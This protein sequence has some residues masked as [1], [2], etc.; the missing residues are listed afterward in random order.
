LGFEIN[1]VGDIVSPTLAKE[2]VKYLHLSL[3]F[4]WV[5]YVVYQLVRQALSAGLSV[6]EVALERVVAAT[7]TQY[8]HPQCPVPRTA[9]GARG[10][11]AE[12]DDQTH[13]AGLAYVAFNCAA[14]PELHLIHDPARLDW[15]PVTAVANY[16]VDAA[17]ISKAETL[18]L[19]KNVRDSQI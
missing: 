14:R 1:E 16:Q 19:Q 5:Y 8:H 13:R 10:R 12:R 6:S 4:V 3:L 11:A 18:R 17:A 7:Q 2:D 9:Q 15:V